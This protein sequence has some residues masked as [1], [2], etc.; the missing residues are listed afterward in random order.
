M[1][2][3][4]VVLTGHLAAEPE[5][6]SFPSGATLIRYLVTTR[7]TAPRRRVDV[8]PVTL[9]DPPAHLLESPGPKGGAVFVAGT[10]Q[11]RFWSV[12][13]G[14]ASRVEVIARHVEFRTAATAEDDEGRSSA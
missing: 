8:V 2:F 13:G 1:D 9:W 3:N 7:V 12:E 6:R 4:I 10:L 11:R 5:I 14:K